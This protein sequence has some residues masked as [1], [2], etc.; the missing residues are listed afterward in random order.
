MNARRVFVL[1]IAPLTLSGCNASTAP[2]RAP[3]ADVAVSS[4]VPVGGAAG[5]DPAAPIT[6]A[7]N[8]SMLPGMELLVLLHEGSVTG[9]VVAG[10]ST[11]SAERTQLTFTPSQTLKS[12]TSY[13]LH[14]S[15]NLRATSGQTINFAS[16]AQLVGGEAVPGGMMNGGMM[17]GSGGPGMMSGPG[18]Q[19]GSGMWGYGMILTFTTQ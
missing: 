11:W 1:L 8:H 3:L 7:F 12:N 14:L 2:P 19:A 15:P 5:V 17:G 10:T 16:C 6:I 4:V 13:V 18:W 9:P